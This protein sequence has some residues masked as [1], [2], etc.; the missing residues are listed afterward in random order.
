MKPIILRSLL[1]VFFLCSGGSL[2][3]WAHD[4]TRGEEV[5]FLNSINFNLPW[6]KSIYWQVHD[7][8]AKKGIQVKAE[9]LSVP[10]LRTLDEVDAM[11]LH[12]KEKFPVPP[13]LVVIIGDPGWMVC[14]EL[15]DKEWK[16]VPVIITNSREYLPKSLEV[17]LS[18]EP[19]TAENTV[20]AKVWREGYNITFLGLACYVK[21]T[22]ELMR[23][24]LPEMK[25][26]A[27]ISDDR[28]ISEVIRSDVESTVKN[29][30]P[31]LD[32]Q[33]LSTNQVTTEMLLD[34]LRS[35]DRS[36]GLIYYSWFESHNRTD[37]N[38]L[39]DHI[40]EIIH[41]FAH[42]PLF[43]LTTEDLTKSTFAGGHYIT[44]D[45]FAKSLLA[46]IY[47]VL[48]GES[49]G[50]IP[51]TDG[52]KP[53][54]TLS[55]PVLQSYDIPVSLYPENV[56]YVNKPRAFLLQYKKEV[57]LSVVALLLIVGAI[58][59]YI[60]I[61][62]KT[63]GRLKEAKEQAENANQLKSAFLANMSHEIRTPLNS[64]VGFSNMLP[65]VETEEEMIEYAEIIEKNTDLLL[66]L[67]ND[68]LDMA[69]IE[70][71]TYDLYETWI[72]VNQV[73]EEI[74]QSA[75]VRIKNNAVNLAFEERLP[76]CKLYTDRNRLVQ[77]ITNFVTNAIK[78]TEKGTIKMGYRLKDA[79]TI[80]FYVS[81][82]GC[83]MS[84]EQCE[85]VFERFIKYNPF[86]QG[87]GLGLS[88]CKMLIEKM[89]GEIGVDSIPG[90][91]SEF[92]FV[93]KYSDL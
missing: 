31:E 40:Q 68:I 66:Q 51:G 67:I 71:G 61:L 93:L 42:T 56:V 5:L 18:H 10:A 55:Y 59:C 65:H 85:H 90:E 8:L 37:N 23:Q 14:R 69:K 76:Q 89:G 26:I 12:L 81:D 35:Y 39:F 64:I 20:P 38:Y 34:T 86:V 80:Y 4:N 9:S 47:R 43:L 49:A 16:D 78:F 22:I 32:L 48:G 82:S 77:V 1:F 70:A 11:L 2:H 88:I 30:F 29:F 7:E 63:Y 33:Q 58:G 25:S 73:M 84:K 87:T 72:D 57:L 53:V 19:L 54:T 75:G 91:G 28:Y 45:S 44:S 36:T 92:W 79:H 62:K 74:Q 46:V 50:D 21:E 3:L 17:L 13:K 15:F 6:A 60:Y 24:L 52:G 41:G 27:F 83:G